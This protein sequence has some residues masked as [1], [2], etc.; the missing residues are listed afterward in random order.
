MEINDAEIRTIMLESKEAEG[1]K[2]KSAECESLE[3]SGGVRDTE[4]F[5]DLCEEAEGKPASVRQQLMKCLL[6][7]NDFF[8]EDGIA[9]AGTDV[10][11]P[12]FFCKGCFRVS[13][14]S[15]R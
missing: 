4:E 2:L 11:A 6:C 7:F 15:L 9:C 13:Y 3:S 14:K 10:D 8:F 12:H 5:D 1:C